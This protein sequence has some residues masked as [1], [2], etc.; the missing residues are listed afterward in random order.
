M[1]YILIRIKGERMVSDEEIDRIAS[2]VAEKLKGKMGTAAIRA[3]EL[4]TPCNPGPKYTCD[5]TSFTCQASSFTCPSDFEC[6][7]KFT[8]FTKE[9]MR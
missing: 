2:R 9:L 3:G 6:S 4:P 8:G 5:A 7:N 1:R